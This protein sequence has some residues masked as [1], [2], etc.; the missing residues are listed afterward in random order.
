MKVPCP[1]CHGNGTL[2]T[3]FPPDGRVPATSNS[4]G[5]LETTFGWWEAPGITDVLTVQ[6]RRI[7]APAPPL[8]AKIPAGAEGGGFHQIT[9]VFP[10]AGCWEITGKAGTAGLTFVVQ[11][12][13]G[14]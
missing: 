5:A 3:T 2:W 6:G 10:T 9:V 1:S 14:E 13:K 12:I 7:D 4:V 11:V 8:L